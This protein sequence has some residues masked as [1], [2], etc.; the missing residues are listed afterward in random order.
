MAK[1]KASILT[2]LSTTDLKRL[3]AARERIDV[4]EKDKARLLKEL[5][6]VDKE[7]AQLMGGGTTRK[8]TTRKKTTKKKAAKKKTTRKKVVKKTTR[9][10][11]TK[12][13]VLMK[14][15]RKPRGAA[16]GKG[17]VTLEDVILKVIKGNK[18]P[19]P[20]K[21]L[22]KAIVGGK[23][24]KTKSANFDNVLR[25]TLSTSKAVKRVG[26]GVYAVA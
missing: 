26:R 22:K 11:T 14:T 18:G 1:K 9:K 6:A 4:L 16:A 2:D 12:K 13:K 20:F 24:F 25:R 8:K 21:D 3:L 19:M 10:K 15:T 17:R 7:L 23:L 5:S